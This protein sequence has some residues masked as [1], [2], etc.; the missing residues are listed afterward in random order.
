MRPPTRA[1]CHASRSPRGGLRGHCPRHRG[2]RRR[3]R[4]RSRRDGGSC[5]PAL[6]V[7]VLGVGVAYDLWAKGTPWSW[8]PFAVGIPLLPV[9]G[10]VGATGSPPGFF[11][12]LVPMAV[13]AGAA[14]AIA[15][16][17]WTWTPIAPRGRG[18][19]RPRSVRS[20]VVARGVPH[21][22]RDAPRRAVR[23]S[24]RVDMAGAC[25]GRRRHGGR[26]DRAR[27]RTGRGPAARRRAREA[28][29]VGAAIAAT[30]WVAGM[31]PGP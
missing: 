6:A 8:L 3:P 18:R 11:A 31:L 7:V 4:S 26:R 13:L 16:A 25:A 22:R 2:R 10:W 19:W 5:G 27:D 21:G 9:Y 17:R 24:E 20:G 14:L 12:V 15:N 28:Q 23:R 29:A 30:G 1:A